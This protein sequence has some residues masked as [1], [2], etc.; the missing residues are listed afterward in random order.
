MAQRFILAFTD[1]DALQEAI[2]DYFESLS[3]WKEE[4][5]TKPDGET[6]TRPYLAEVIPPTLA[7]LAHHLGVVRQT[8]WNYQRRGIE[9]DDPIGPVI[10]RALNRI[11][12]WN[13]RALYSREG[14]RGAMFALEVNYGY[15]REEGAG[16]GTS[17]RQ[18]ITPP[19][20]AEQATAIPKWDG[21]DDDD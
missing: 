10:A 1:P 6:L 12:G 13:E 21:K 16:T 2:D 20:P 5:V 15:G 8:L 4:I 11:A 14:T 19:A 18:V 3:V 7:D 9:E 17:F